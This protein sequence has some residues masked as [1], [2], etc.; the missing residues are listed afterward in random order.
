VSRKF[1]RSLLNVRNKRGA[2]INSDHHLVIADFRMRILANTKKFE[3]CNKRYDVHKL[4][5]EQLRKE[6][7]IQLQNR[8]EALSYEG[9]EDVETTWRRMRDTYCEVSERVLGFRKGEKKEWMSEETWEVITRRKQIKSKINTSKTRQQKALAQAEYMEA[10][11]IVKRSVRRDRRKW[12][13]ELAQKAEEAARRNDMKELYSITK[14]SSKKKFNRNRPV[15]N[16]RGDLLRTQEEQLKI[17]EEHFTEVLNRD[18]GVEEDQGGPV[19]EDPNISLHSPTEAEIKQAL[20][21][22]KNGKAPGIDNIP[23]EVLKLDID[24]AAKF[25]QPLL[26]RIWVE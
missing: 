15:R 6:F 12:A 13:D 5:K 10:D 18:T 22:I 21:Q 14:T 3:K 16:K 7:K 1:R 24:L 4:R 19:H 23:P 11:K 26:E 25:I 17:W 20:K 8:Y 9:E 2:D